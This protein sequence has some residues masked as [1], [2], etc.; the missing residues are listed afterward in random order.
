MDEM[1]V[2]LERLET[3]RALYA[4]SGGENPEEDAM[5]KVRS[6]AEPRGLLDAAGAR[7]FGRNTYPTTNPE[8]HG[9][10][11]YLTV[12]PDVEDGGGLEICGVPGGLYAVL[13]FK[14]LER[15]TE[16]WGRIHAWVEESEYENIDWVKG[17]HGWALGYEEHLNPGEKSQSEWEFD[18]WV[19]LKE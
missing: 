1:E 15:I 9:Y 14:G 2:R 10:E 12:G 6:W 11:F 4:H 3:T 19:Q 17:E 16:A 7:I 5:A 18:L 8:P 13:R